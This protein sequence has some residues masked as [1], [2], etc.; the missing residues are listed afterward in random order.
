MRII[1]GKFRGRELSVP[2]AVARPTTDR[3]REALFSIIHSVIPGARC[4]D[5][6]A[7]SGALGIEALSRGATS[8][9]FADQD[10]SAVNT[11][12]KNLKN[13]DLAA[14]V[15]KM[16]ALQ[17]NRFEN[18]SF[19]LIF[20]DP[21]YVKSAS[22]RDYVAELLEGDLIDKLEGSGY[23]IIEASAHHNFREPSNW[24][25]VTQRSYGSCGI[26]I[27]QKSQV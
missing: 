17:V 20:A 7:G 21:P 10:F 15:L 12:N 27:F 24:E 3:T 25:I 4:L 5:L 14:E 26:T 11:I 9:V 6:F 18:K 22:D 8:C 2:A 23:F 13:L 1:S 19:D 16:D